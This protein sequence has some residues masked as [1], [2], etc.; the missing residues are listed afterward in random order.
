M[1]AEENG[2]PVPKVI[3]FGIAK[4]TNDQPLADKTL[5]TAFEQFLGTPAYMSPEQAGMGEMD[6]DTRTDIY[7]LGALLYEL[8]A[9]QPPFS[10]EELLRCALDETLQIIRNK[11]PLSP[12][13]RVASFGGE[14]LSHAAA[15][16]Q[17]EPLKLP[18]LLR[19]ELDWI[20]MKALEKDRTRRYESANAVALDVQRFLE[21]EPIYARPPSRFYQLKKMAIRHAVLF[22][23]V[24]AVA[25]TLVG[26]FAISSWLFLKE[27]A[28]RQRA[29]D[30]EK[31]DYTLD[32]PKGGVL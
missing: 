30:A 14:L 15:A 11:E 8:L 10:N 13:L 24:G 1:V 20:V 22:T 31:G 18:K 17:S 21:N 28:A 7:S 4:A 6:I 16:R 3:D 27:K 23:A 29:V 32:S 25:L 2:C 9:G 5:Y 26:G 19:G 12:S